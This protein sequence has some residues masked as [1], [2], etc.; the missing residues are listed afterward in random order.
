MARWLKRLRARLVHAQTG[1]DSVD[2]C[3]HRASPRR[4][5]HDPTD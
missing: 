2:G 4:P 5:T 1:N 3:C